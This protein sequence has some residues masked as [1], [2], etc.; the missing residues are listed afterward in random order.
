MPKQILIVGGAG[1]IGAA[2]VR[3]LLHHTQAEVTIA[4]RDLPRAQAAATQLHGRG[5]ARRLDLSN[6]TCA[7]L[8]TVVGA[9][10]LV[11]QCTGPFRTL[12]PTLLQACIDGRVDYVDICDDK[13]ATQARLAM[14]QAATRAGITALIDTGTFPGIDNVIVADALA[15]HPQAD[16][17]HLSF[18]CAGSGDGGF[19]VLQ[20]TFLAVSRAYE[21]WVEGRWQST[22]SYRGRTVMDFG[23]PMGRRPV[24]NFEVPELWSLVH[25]FPQLTTCTSRFGTVP[26]LWNWATWLLASAPRAMRE[27]PA[28][29]DRSADFILPVVH[30]IDR[31]VGGALG[32]RVDLG[33]EDTDGRHIET[34]TFYAPSTSQAVG[35]ATGLAAAMV[36]DGEID[37]AGVLLPETHIP[38]ASYLAR[39]AT[40]GAQLQRTQTTLR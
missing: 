38:A 37:A 18:V 25:T 23:H 10:D 6:A 7:E 32:I 29:L 15:R 12:P 39:L 16:T 31:W 4:G 9:Y 5:H 33:F 2:V 13:A 21:Q 3:D 1:K 8:T 28:F 34:T 11:L 36:L 19:G 17:V 30:W 35:W 26:E 27:D 22:P 24:Y 14:N 40:R 20:T